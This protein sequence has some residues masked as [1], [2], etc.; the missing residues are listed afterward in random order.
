[1]TCTDKNA[2]IELKGQEKRPDTKSRNGE[3]LIKE[4]GPGAV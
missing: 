4:R 1:M 2:V 3:P